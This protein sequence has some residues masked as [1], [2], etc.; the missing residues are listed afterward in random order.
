MQRIVAEQGL[1]WIA[2]R[3]PLWIERKAKLVDL[4]KRYQ[5][6]HARLQ[7]AMANLGV[8]AFLSGH[9][10]WYFHRGIRKPTEPRD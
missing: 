2:V 4:Y 1:R 6:R 7:Q 8:D 9:E 5:Q 10:G 3:E